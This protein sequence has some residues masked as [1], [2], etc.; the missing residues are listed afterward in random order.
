MKKFFH[1]FLNSWTGKIITLNT[2]VFGIMSIY[3]YLEFK[4]WEFTETTLSQFGAIHPHESSWYSVATM[5]FLHGGLAHIVCNSISLHNIGSVL[6]K[7]AKSWFLPVY[8][9]SG[10]VSGITVYFY[11]SDWT[12]GA[13]GAI[14][15]IW[16]M[17]IVHNMKF[18]RSKFMIIATMIDLS[19]LVYISSLPKISALGHFSGFMVGLIVGLVYFTYFFVDEE[20]ILLAK[21]KAEIK[22]RNEARLEEMRIEELQMKTNH[23]E[24]NKIIKNAQE[25]RELSERR[26]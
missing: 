18:L 10:L 24:W 12:V 16:A 20:S 3:N 19:L 5:M 7:H 1:K 8:I 22:S 4:S 14:C 26:I 13:S 25:I 11:G 9:I 17:L 15:G 23:E 21:E 2:L 6:E